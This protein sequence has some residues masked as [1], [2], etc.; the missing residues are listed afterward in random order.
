M[1]LEHFTTE[2]LQNE[3]ERR[4]TNIKS[5]EVTRPALLPIGSSGSSMVNYG[6]TVIA[7]VIK[8]TFD[9]DKDEVDL[10]DLVMTTLY[11]ADFWEW[12][13]KHT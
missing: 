1:G 9:E 13:N 10:F 11:G 8:G 2:A 12:F 7:E 4:E 6:E 3:I 5:R